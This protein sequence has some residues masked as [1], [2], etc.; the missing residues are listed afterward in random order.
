MGHPHPTSAVKGIIVESRV[1]LNVVKIKT[2]PLH[3]WR[4]NTNYCVN[5]VV[6]HPQVAIGV[7]LGSGESVIAQTQCSIVGIDA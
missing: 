7:K 5:L 4:Q 3:V 2:F 6:E 1:F